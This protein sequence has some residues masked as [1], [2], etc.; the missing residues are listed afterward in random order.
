MQAKDLE[1]YKKKLL[2]MR[3]RSREEINRMIQV[4]LEEAEAPGEHD[5]QV[6]ESVAKEIVLEHTEEEM[7]KAVLAALKRIEAGT[8]GQCEQCGGRIPK[9]RLDAL[10]FTPRCVNCE[11]EREQ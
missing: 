2:E 9:A 3:N 8:Y 5:H 1:R 6:S 11:R 4:V 7:R 10:P